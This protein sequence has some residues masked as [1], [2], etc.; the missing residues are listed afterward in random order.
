[1][2]YNRI[3]VS[4]GN[5]TTVEDRRKLLVERISASRYLV[6]SARLRDLL[7]YLCERVLEGDAEEIHEQEVGHKVF[8]R[9]ADYDTASD[10]IVR[11]H[12]SMLRKRLEQ[13]FSTEGAAE[14]LIIEI[15]K[16]NYAP[17][18]HER[19]AREKP[20]AEVVVAPAPAKLDWRIPV[21]AALALLF[22]GTTLF[23]AV[24]RLRPEA[25]APGGPNVRLFWSQIFRPNQ[26]TD[27]VL[28]DAA[29]GLYQEL[30]GRPLTLADYFDRGYL[31]S[32][33]ETAAHV[34]ID[35]QAATAMVLRRQ[36]SYAGATFLWKLWQQAG[37]RMTQ[38]NL[39]FARDYTFHA[40][41]G[42]NAI[43]MGNSR[44]NP[45]VEPFERKM[46]LHWIFDPAANLYYPVEGS[47][48][49]R[50][51][52]N[53]EARRGYAVIALLP[54][55]GGNGNVLLISA[56]GGSAM[57][58]AADFLLD[59]EAVARLRRG[60]PEPDAKRF[61]SFEALLLLQGRSTRPRD[62]TIVVSRLLH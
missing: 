26:T 40:L 39:H 19:S 54:N 41:R 1:M 3:T 32:L 53:G 8:G 12:A 44:S 30:T 45:W 24:P 48:T 31:R 11:V 14:P 36:S 7:V 6:R 52:E 28:D 58:S 15:P 43:L 61:P 20:L 10:N 25:A 16:G 9:P 57:N 4:R 56:T 49:Y 13:Y 29:I 34:N 55:L 59:E 17:V 27:I 21:L 22:A 51:T 60:L 5:G 35:S 18:F 37:S 62:S 23:L 50:P 42:D 46:G 33:P 38:A 47:Q 2:N